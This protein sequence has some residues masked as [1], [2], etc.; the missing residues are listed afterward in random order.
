MSSQTAEQ[1]TGINAGPFGK[2]EAGVLE[3]PT[4]PEWDYKGVSNAAND[5]SMGWKAEIPTPGFEWSDRT[6]LVVEFTE[7]CPDEPFDT[8]YSV[9]LLPFNEDGGYEGGVFQPVL[10]V[11]TYNRLREA[12]RNV[13]E[14]LRKIAE[15]DAGEG[16]IIGGK[17]LQIQ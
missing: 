13:K 15:K 7:F 10:N 5:K 4:Y 16:I 9:A 12:L 2:V 3:A 14:A 8:G 17:R 11:G 1:T 6:T